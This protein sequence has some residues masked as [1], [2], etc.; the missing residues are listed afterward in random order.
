MRIPLWQL[1]TDTFKTVNGPLRSALGGEKY[2]K[3]EM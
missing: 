1:T 3:T 2:R